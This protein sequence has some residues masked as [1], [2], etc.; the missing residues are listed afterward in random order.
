MLTYFDNLTFFGFLFSQ[1]AISYL[2]TTLCQNVRF[3]IPR[4]QIH[5]REIHKFMLNLTGCFNFH[6]NPQS[7]RSTNPSWLSGLLG[8]SEWTPETGP[9][10]FCLG[11]LW[12]LGG[13]G[14]GEGVGEFFSLPSGWAVGVWGVFFFP[15]LVSMVGSLKWRGGGVW[16]IFFPRW[17][18]P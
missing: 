11:S 5:I 15:S 16:I 7:K 9:K 4:S 1:V 10:Q 3:P 2:S 12:G 17:W 13:V 8:N 14:C 18:A 6:P